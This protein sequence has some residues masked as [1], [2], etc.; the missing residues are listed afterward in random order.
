MKKKTFVISAVNLTSGGPL[1]ILRECLQAAATSLPAEWDIVALVH[2]PAVLVQ[3]R[4]RF[5]A[6]PHTLGSWGRRLWFEWWTSAKLSRTLNADVWLSLQDVSSHT[7]ARRQYVYCHNAAPFY[8]ASWKEARMGPVFFMQTLFYKL[9]YRVFLRRN[10]GVIVQQDWMRKKFQLHFGGDLNIIVARPSI[11]PIEESIPPV[12]VKRNVFFYPSLPRVFKNF[13]I[14]CEAAVILQ[15]RGIAGQQ[16]RLTISGKE[17]TY[18]RDL[19]RRFSKTEGVHFIGH[20]SRESMQREYET[21]DVVIFP[22]KLESWG[23]PISEAKGF[24]KT[25]FL[26]DL[27][28]AHEALGSYDRVAFFPVTE[29][30]ALADLVVRH[31]SGSTPTITVTRDQPDPPVSANWGE[32][33]QLM[34]IGL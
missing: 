30:K 11:S 7:N 2:N 14:V 9:L 24:G 15:Q 29:P 3:P 19:Y 21:A 1:S 26:A 28:Y 25:L 5:I 18:A 33:F 31:M 10:N 34:T 12:Q 23:L 20:Q 8:K 27:A 4:V 16:F 6:V 32:L 13:E 17:N 22:S